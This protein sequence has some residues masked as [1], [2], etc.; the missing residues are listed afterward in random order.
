MVKVIEAKFERVIKKIQELEEEFKEE[1]D[2]E[3][4]L[5]EE[6]TR[7]KTEDGMYWEEL[8]KKMRIDVPEFEKH[9]KA[10]EE[11]ANK[12]F[13]EIQS[14][15]KKMPKKKLQKIREKRVIE[16]RISA[17]LAG[18]HSPGWYFFNSA[19]YGSGS[20]YT[21]NEGGTTEGSYIPLTWGTSNEMNPRSYAGGAGSG[22]S[23]D[24]YVFTKS[25]HW[26]YIPSSYITRP[27]RIAVWPY[28][29][30]H[31]YYWVRANDGF[32]TSKEARIRLRMCTRLYQ[33]YWTPWHIWTVK[34]RGNDN[35]NE[36]NRVDYSGYNHNAR[37][38][39]QVGA[40][41]GVYVQVM[42]ELF[43]YTEGSGSQALWH[44]QKH[45]LTG[46]G[47]YIRIPKIAVWIP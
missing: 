5:E 23:D 29:D 3:F 42:A 8:V 24:N 44:L 15:M 38:L 39:L 26:F 20:V 11:K 46:P 31:G 47:N 16:D 33:Y 10:D 37:A 18:E 32:W 21:H 25:W 30:V 1:A 12:R 40:G 43:S 36:T 45:V 28:F 27:V 13:E 17:R 19:Y 9:Q 4:A 2:R 41:D 7:L 34:N 6:F 35:I 22:F 14:L